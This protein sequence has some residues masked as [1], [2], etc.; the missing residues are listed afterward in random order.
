MVHLNFCINNKHSSKGSS[1][2]RT[3]KHSIEES[4]ELLEVV[5]YLTTGV[6]AEP[7]I[8]M[9]LKKHSGIQQ[10]YSFT[11]PPDFGSLAY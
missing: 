10:L 7:C 9:Q 4:G 2:T 5:K 3:E 1:Y 6:C 8:K 11:F